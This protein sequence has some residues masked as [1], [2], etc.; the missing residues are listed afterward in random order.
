MPGFDGVRAMDGVSARDGG[1]GPRR[2]GSNV[3]R[4]LRMVAKRDHPGGEP[5]LDWLDKGS[6][7]RRIVEDGLVRAVPGTEDGRRPCIV[8]LTPAGE[9]ALAAAGG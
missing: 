2:L 1:G 3:V 8:V 6:A 5:R 7:G 9:A 4:M